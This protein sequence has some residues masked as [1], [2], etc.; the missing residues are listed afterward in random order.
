MEQVLARFRDA[1]VVGGQ[2]SPGS[3]NNVFRYKVAD[4]SITL[5]S[6]LPNQATGSGAYDSNSPAISVGKQDRDIKT[7]TPVD[8]TDTS[9]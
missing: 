2:S 6:H 1:L 7:S 8:R 5:V 4:G 3:F 9:G